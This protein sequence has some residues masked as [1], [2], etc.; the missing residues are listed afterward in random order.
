MS[1]ALRL[2]GRDWI[3]NVQMICWGLDHR[4]G[5][6][7]KELS[8]LPKIGA[9]LVQTLL[10]TGYVTLGMS[11]SISDPVSWGGGVT[12][13]TRGKPVTD[14]RA[15]HPRLG[16]FVLSA[17]TLRWAVATHTSTSTAP[18]GGVARTRQPESIAEG[19]EGFW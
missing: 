16:I 4:T 2:R 17:H 18:E 13:T 12:T 10:L 8:F 3:V 11:L 14:S 19:S 1:E 5:L 15:P 9:G 6:M 7:M